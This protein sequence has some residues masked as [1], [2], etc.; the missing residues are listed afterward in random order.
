MKS[1]KIY[2]S[3]CLALFMVFGLAEMS[4]AQDDVRS[5]AVE[6]YNNATELAGN[7]EFDDAI[8]FYREALAI[9]RE[10]EGLS[11][12][13]DFIVERL[14]RVYSSRAVNTYREFQN[15][16]NIETLSRSIE[17]FESAR[18]VANEFDDAQVEQQATNNIPQLYYQRGLLNFRAENFDE[19][20]AD[21]DE[22]IELNPNYAA[23]YYQ[24]GIVQKQITPNDVDA[25]IY[26]YDRAID[27]AEN[28][29]DNRTLNSAKSGA[30]DE[31]IYRA[32]NLAD[33]R[34]FNRAIELLQRAEEYDPSYY[35]P[36][37]RLSVIHN[38]RGNWSSAENSARRSLELHTGGAADKAKIYFELGTALKGQG[39]VESACDAFE[40]ARFG[41]F[42]DPANHELQ[43][44]LRCEG[45]SP[46][47]N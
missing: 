30:R 8:V 37:Y 19:S 46:T 25:F 2:L 42:T 6:L 13:T 44:E 5:E 35:E 40:N 20:M 4:K 47:G 36:H 1:L 10:H 41:N 39:N 21:L 16:R 12:I 45:H 3:Y 24:K 28:V 43:F 17:Y 23:A 14:P 18:D 34:N 7:N 11:D 33:E 31:L 9:S 38:E 27:V 26:W 22:A 15:N 29:N 32:V